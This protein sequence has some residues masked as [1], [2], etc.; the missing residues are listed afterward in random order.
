MFLTTTPTPALSLDTKTNDQSDVTIEEESIEPR[1]DVGELIARMTAEQKIGQLMMIGILESQMTPNLQKRIQNIKPGFLILFRKN[2][3]TPLQ[4]ASLIYN[5]QTQSRKTSSMQMLVAVDQ[6]GGD[7]VRIPT[8]PSLPTAMALGRSFDLESTFN[9]G[10]YIGEV[11]SVLGIH[12]NL[13]PVLDLSD[14]EKISFIQTRSFGDNPIDVAK[15]SNEFARGVQSSGV[16]STAK[17]FPGLGHMKEDSHK[18]VVHNNVTKQEFFSKYIKPYEEL[19]KEKSIS[20]V[21]MTHLVYPELDPSLKPATFSAPI[22]NILKNNIKFSGLI[23][24]DD[25]EMAGAKFY[26]TP[27]ERAVQAFLAG[28]DVLMVAWNKSSQRK[29]YAGLLRAYKSGEISEERLNSSL[30]KILNLKLS[31]NLNKPL[32]KPNPKVI[33]AKLRDNTL[34]EPVDNIFEKIMNQELHRLGD[35]K[36]SLDLNHVTVV[37]ADYEF[38]RKFKSS[39]RHK[40]N[41]LPLTKDFTIKNHAGSLNKSS[42]VIVNVSGPFSTL[43]ANALPAQL[44]RRSI[45]LNSRYLGSIKNEIDFLDVLQLSMKHADVGSYLGSYLDSYSTMGAAL[46]RGLSSSKVIPEQ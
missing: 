24:T 42:L 4:T 13:A 16:V 14:P 43:V 35:K 40:S 12:M 6:E 7:V 29:A 33:I 36:D 31:M 38:Y 28:N 10:K 15:I 27:E 19:S 9:I 2:I 34:K 3:I 46:E 1:I 26:R 11:L 5:V 23:M 21:M 25:V 20:A 44:K 18:S 37:S 22:I 32:V 41:F 8:K 45:I 39:Y 30:K 17:H